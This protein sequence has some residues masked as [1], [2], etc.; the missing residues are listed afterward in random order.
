MFL[1]LLLLLFLPSIPVRGMAEA[2]FGATMKTLLGA[3]FSLLKGRFSVL[4]FAAELRTGALDK[5]RLD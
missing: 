1:F 4:Q 5:T 3:E 2:F